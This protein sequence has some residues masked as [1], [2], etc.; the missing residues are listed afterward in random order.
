MALIFNKLN[1]L[2]ESIASCTKAIDL[3]SSYLKAILHRARLY[4]QKEMYDDAVHDYEAALRIDPTV[5]SLKK[6]LQNTKLS[7]KKAKRKDYYKILNVDKSATEDEIRK[8]YKKRALLHHP[9][10]HAS[11]PEAVQREQEKLFKDLGEAYEVLSD[12]KK[13]FR[14][15]QGVDLMDDNPGGGY[16]SYHDPSADFLN[17]FF[18]NGGI[19]SFRPGQASGGG[20][21]PHHQF[22]HSFR[23]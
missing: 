19:P 2:D 14:Y 15:D 18:A 23:H 9:D 12:S 1:K 17:V 11:A 3:N 8:A 4:C 20:R 10:R 16:A 5:P 13:R 7:A 22:H 6:E 21:G